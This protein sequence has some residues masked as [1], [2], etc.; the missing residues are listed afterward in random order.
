M[1][2]EVWGDKVTIVFGDMR[3][4]KAPEKVNNR[5]FIIPSVVINDLVQTNSS[6]Y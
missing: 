1:K 4:W 2:S 5:V 6:T 3:E